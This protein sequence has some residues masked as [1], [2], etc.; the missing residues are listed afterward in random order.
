MNE[1]L[2]NEIIGDYEKAINALIDLDY[3]FFY[4]QPLSSGAMGVVFN[5]HQI[6]R[7]ESL[8]ELEQVVNSLLFVLKGGLVER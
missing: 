7:C 2:K 4:I 8:R 5:G 6:A 1:Y 3:N